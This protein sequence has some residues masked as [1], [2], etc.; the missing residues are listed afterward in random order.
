MVNIGDL[1]AVESP[2]GEFIGI[3]IEHYPNANLWEYTVIKCPDGE[4][5]PC[6]VAE[7]TVMNTPRQATEWER[8]KNIEKILD[9]SKEHV[10]L[11]NT[12]QPTTKGSEHERV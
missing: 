2:Y 9:K 3:V 4:P 1:V 10:I 11:D 5:V 7:L 6:E 8:K 12:I